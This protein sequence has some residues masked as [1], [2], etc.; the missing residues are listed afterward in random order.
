MSEVRV[1]ICGQVKALLPWSLYHGD[2]RLLGSLGLDHHKALRMI[3][4]VGM[5]QG[6]GHS[7]TRELSSGAISMQGMERRG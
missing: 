3:Q 4:A 1:I 5:N 6:S 7:G 2:L